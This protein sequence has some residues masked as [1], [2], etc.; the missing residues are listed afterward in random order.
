ME[1]DTRKYYTAYDD[2][3]KTAHARGVSWASDISTPIVLETV[4]KYHR[5]HAQHFLEIGC[6]EGRDARLLLRKGYNLVATDISA[7][8]VTYCKE[9]LPQYADRFKILDCLSDKPNSTFDFIYAV[10]VVHMLVP[11]EDR[12]G[13][14]RFIHDCLSP[15]GIALICTMG[16]GQFETQSDIAQA[17]TLQQRHHASGSML[18]AGTSCR[19][20]SF[21]TFENEIARNDLLILEKGITGSLPEFDKLMYAVVQKI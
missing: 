3:Y 13:F 16:D 9:Q 20:V 1:P 7:E 10:A 12:N 8:A 6:G 2:R 5:S 18:V 15:D 21:E 11:D 19:M 14:Y 17:F 4:E